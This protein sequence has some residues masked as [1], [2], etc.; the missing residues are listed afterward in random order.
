MEEPTDRVLRPLVEQFTAPE[1]RPAELV[2]LDAAH[3]QR[4]ED[5]LALGVTH[6]ERLDELVDHLVNPPLLRAPQGPLQ[7][8]LG[9]RAAHEF[10]VR[11]D[12]VLRE[13]QV[14][15]AAGRPGGEQPQFGIG[16][17]HPDAPRQP[18]PGL[19][20]VELGER[21]DR[22]LPIPADPEV[23]AAEPRQIPQEA[24]EDAYQH[25]QSG[26]ADQGA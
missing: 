25:P 13:I 17:P 20:E 12:L 5:L 21:L 15:V 26:A 11:L 14:A 23:A 4:F 16:G 10:V 18:P 6:L 19:V 7:G 1:R 24:N 3:R 2:T 9:G 22:F 8:L